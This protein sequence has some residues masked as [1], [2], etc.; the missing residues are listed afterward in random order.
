MAKN[1]STRWINRREFLGG[2]SAL[3]AFGLPG[4][5]AASSLPTILKPEPARVHLF[6]DDERQ[7][8]IWAYNQT[9]PGPTL[10]AKRGEQVQF[11]LEN[12]LQQAT[13]IHW[14]GIRIDNKMDGVAN[15]TQPPVEPGGQFDYVFTPPDAGTYWYHPHFKSWEQ[16]ARGLSGPLIIEEDEPQD[17]DQDLIFAI[18]D[19][20]LQQ[21]LS[22][23]E[24]SLGNLGD[25]AHAGRLGN[26]LTVN[27]SG[28]T[29][30][31]VSPGQRC[32][33]RLMNFATARVFN[34]DFPKLEPWIIAVDG[35]PTE[36]RRLTDTPLMLGP[37]QRYDL[38]VDIP[39]DAAGDLYID[40]IT[41]GGRFGAAAFTVSGP[42]QPARN[43]A[44]A[45]L[46]PN[47]L[48][49]PDAAKAQR[50]PLLMEGGAMGRM[51]S[52][53][54]DG[55]QMEIREMARSKK[56]VWAF[57]GIAG[58]IGD[59]LFRVERGRHVVI[60][61]ENR[62]S[63]QH[64]MHLHGHHARVNSRNG[65]PAAVQDW[66]DTILMQPNDRVEAA[67]VADNPGKWMLH[68]HMLGHQAAGMST[69]FEVVA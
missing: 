23:D 42:A 29:R 55:K 51:A 24:R 32:R 4:I 12:G 38:V 16:V 35:Q 28:N 64:A 45:A 18:D 53:I 13:T 17:F 7:T 57:N 40:E 50:V 3:S 1:C 30:Y 61:F 68:C 11:R 52:A 48:A 22:F 47:N 10:T 19:W 21:D 44:P 2:V 54:V 31:D 25:W 20:R 41:R 60:E 33:L 34:L 39:E 59:P 49:E 66:N 36:P 58:I 63:W 65:K 62:T 8:D 46:P 43:R 37:A 6:S 14:H 69:W 67:L 26:A 56:L 5:A 27:G 15:M 9:A